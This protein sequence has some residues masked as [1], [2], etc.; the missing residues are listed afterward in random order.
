M[1]ACEQWIANGCLIRHGLPPGPTCGH[2]PANCPPQQ[3]PTEHT[4]THPTTLADWAH[5]CREKAAALLENAGEWDTLGET[6]SAGLDRSD[7]AGAQALAD[8]VGGLALRSTANLYP[9]YVEAVE[10]L[11]ARLDRP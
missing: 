9:P 8:L 3:L 7:A 5:T 1:L 11:V 2:D 10:R 6:D 4:M